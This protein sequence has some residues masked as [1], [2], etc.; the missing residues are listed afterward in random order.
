MK[1][2]K[3]AIQFIAFVLIISLVT[4]CRK[5]ASPAAITPTAT[6]DSNQ[7]II[8]A[9]IQD[10]QSVSP[11]AA[12]QAEQDMLNILRD[13]SGARAAFGDQA[14]TIFL[15]IDQL[16]AA[17]LEAMKT[18]V[19][20]ALGNNPKVAALAARNGN[21]DI[22]LASFPDSGNYQMMSTVG[23]LMMFGL[24]MML[25]ANVMNNRDQNGNAALP[26]I[27]GGDP[28]GSPGEHFSWQATLS[29][30]RLEAKGK[31]TITLA[32]PFPYTETAEY[33]LY[34]DLCPDADGN[35]PL[36][37]SFNSTV[38]LLGGGVQLGTNSQVTGHVN[39]DAKLTTWD[40]Q[41]TFQGAR[42]PIHGVG[43]NLGTAN[44]YFEFQLNTTL[45]MDGSH[46]TTPPTGDFIRQSAERDPQFIMDAIRSLAF[47]KGYMTGMAMNFAEEKWTNGYCLEITVPE[48][49]ADTKTVEPGSSTPFTAH[50][51][52]KF[53]GAEL[54]LPVVAT[55]SAGQ[56][57]VTPSG[58]KV[59]APAA[60]TYKAADQ[61]GQSATVN[62][63]TR[64][65]RGIAKL[66]IQFKTGELGWKI[67][68]FN[69]VNLNGY[70][71]T[72]GLNCASPYGPWELKNEWT[73]PGGGSGT[74]TWKI[75]F[76]EDG[77]VTGTYNE[78]VTGSDGVVGDFN[79][80]PKVKVIQVEGEYRMDFD[81]FRVTGEVCAPGAGCAPVDKVVNA[82]S[83]NIVP[84]NPGQCP[85]P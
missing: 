23:I 34:M 82:W 1:Q 51:R 78:H 47:M 36:Q 2:R 43:Q 71:M 61:G 84:A 32:Q 15:Q 25:P 80:A 3:L 4:G 63:E 6:P 11:E 74:Q 53:E 30:S 20:G 38:G 64:S 9:A 28:I 45:N 59:P 69:D 16:R 85:Q 26:V 57:S 76:S 14:D 21:P 35:V 83:A 56:V 33:T 62:L 18:G 22:F 10:S 68:D 29:G 67:D 42:Q 31:I 44:N 17:G 49:G 24:S 50:V 60:F 75:P 81:S 73:I 46:S 55:L 12:E 54:P 79:G 8:N 58:S 27:E 48:L 19:I 66:D 37:F 72:G 70:K 7:E 52:H 41:S 77:N 40:D 39:D 5:G 13:Q 65:K